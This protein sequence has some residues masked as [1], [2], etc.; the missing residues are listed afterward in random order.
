M[1]L[2]LSIN[3]QPEPQYIDDACSESLSSISLG[4]LYNEPLKTP[5]PPS[6][7][8]KAEIN[9]LLEE[10]N[11]E[12][13]K[14]RQEFGIESTD[15]ESSLSIQS[16][17][18]ENGDDDVIYID[19]DNNPETATIIEPPITTTISVEEATVIPGSITETEI[20]VP[21]TDIVG[22]ASELDLQMQRE[23]QQ[24][25]IILNER[26]EA[27]KY[28]KDKVDRW[29]NDCANDF[30]IPCLFG[31]EPSQPEPEVTAR[32]QVIVPRHGI[33]S[34]LLVSQTSNKTNVI[35]IQPKTNAEVTKSI[36]CPS[37]KPASFPASSTVSTRN[38]A[39]QV[40][41]SSKR[42]T[43]E[44]SIQVNTWSAIPV[45]RTCETATQVDWT[46]F[47]T[48]SSLLQSQIDSLNRQIING[49]IYEVDEDDQ[50]VLSTQAQVNRN[51][52]NHNNLLIMRRS[53]V[54][55][56]MRYKI[57]ANT[58]LCQ[59]CFTRERDCVLLPC[60]HLLTCHECAKNWKQHNR[61]NNGTA[62]CPGCRKPIKSLQKI[63][64]S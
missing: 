45:L 44:A 55:R 54:D 49:E 7:P 3:Q 38:N 50:E 28:L 23:Q 59:I 57:K 48:S 58:T 10:L 53:T 16:V 19:D 43:C 52:N 41:I 4:D 21:S 27:M 15:G 24:V 8:T 1:A 6:W 32:V 46:D 9:K 30:N 5:P 25:G 17:A 14:L 20:V 61:R 40:N 62:T 39:T 42:K 31:Q 60:R 26:F 47:R 34:N 18:F 36:T 56:L 2:N 12:I 13:P 51:S 33:N 64:Y 63:Y 22:Q 37:P 29:L 35:A 11:Q